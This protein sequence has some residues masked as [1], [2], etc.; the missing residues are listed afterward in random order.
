[1]T[2]TDAGAGP[3]PIPG[4]AVAG[5]GAEIRICGAAGEAIATGG[6]FT[7]T[8]AGSGAGIEPMGLA[9]GIGAATGIGAGG[10]AANAR[11]MSSLA[12]AVPSAP[13]TGHATGL[14]M[15][16]CTGSTSKAYF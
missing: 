7:R 2:G 5:T 16:P 12:A 3:E 8:I 11:A 6:A 9:V 4:T 14:G 15:R 10:A 1:M 13:Q